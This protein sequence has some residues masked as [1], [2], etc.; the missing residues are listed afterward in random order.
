MEGFDEVFHVPIVQGWGMTETSPLGAVALP[1][2]NLAPERQLEYRSKT[3]RV[4]FGVEI[5]AVDAEGAVCPRDGTSIGE[6]EIRGPW[7]TGE[8]YDDPTPSRFDEGW[9]RTGDVG[10]LDAQGFMQITDR[11]KDVIKSGGE[12]ISSVEIENAL[13]GHPA[14]L[15]AAVVAVPDARWDERPLAC[16]VL[17]AGQHAS[18]SELAGWLGDKMPRWWV[19][20][21]WSFVSEIP[22]TSVGKFDKKLLRAGQSQGELEIVTIEPAGH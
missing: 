19:P 21:R 22:K 18:A 7:V 16:V 17:V 6:F 11:T 3:G 1:P 13:M 20:E 9:L 4:S 2:K 8:Y 14:V 15:E 12:W 5:R 10:T